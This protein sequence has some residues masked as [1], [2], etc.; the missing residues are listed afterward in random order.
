MV[1]LEVRM[2]TCRAASESA[3]ITASAVTEIFRCL[4]TISA[5][6]PFAIDFKGRQSRVL[7]RNIPLRKT[8]PRLGR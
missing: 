7:R 4:S 6:L 5:S 8:N 1:M 2:A 3:A